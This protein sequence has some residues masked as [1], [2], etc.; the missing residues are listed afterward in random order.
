MIAAFLASSF[1]RKIAGY[2][3]IALAVAAGI[4]S[5]FRSGKR[6]AKVEA[7]ETSLDNVKVANEAKREVDRAANRGD[8]ADSV[9]GFYRD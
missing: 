1:G 3:A 2:A 4:F 6:A 9:R 5:V 8:V 7:L